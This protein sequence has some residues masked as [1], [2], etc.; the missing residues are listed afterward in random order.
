M[1]VA[2]DHPATQANQMNPS[3]SSEGGT[4]VCTAREPP[5]NR[6]FTPGFPWCR[7]REAAEDRRLKRRP[8]SSAL[9]HAEFDAVAGEYATLHRRNI[10]A[11][12]DAPDYFARYKIAEIAAD[13]LRR[14][15]RNDIPLTIADF[16]GG[17]GA[18]IPH[19]RS[20]F[21]DSRILEIDVS[22]RSLALSRLRH[23][24]MADYI[25]YDGRVLPL[26]E[27]SVD[28]ALAACVFHHIPSAE[29]VPLIAAMARAL[30]PGGSYYIFEHNPWN[31]LTR[32]AV[33]TCPFD[34]NAILIS[35]PR[36]AA[37]VRRAGLRAKG[38]VYRY[39]FPAALRALRPLEPWLGAAPI[40][41]QYFVRGLK[42]ATR[43]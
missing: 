14:G 17:I 34:E 6:K 22:R 33:N 29:H 18:S 36:L 31:P 30:K 7:D 40:G 15:L 37:R 20:Y 35:G 28:F 4:F 23:G 19:L 39:F 5:S 12:G 25:P 9:S 13:R 24:P 3:R 21:P 2:A 43:S 11:S 41:A 10:A 26:A 16:G 27:A 38:P 1:G 8:G 42:L 32:H